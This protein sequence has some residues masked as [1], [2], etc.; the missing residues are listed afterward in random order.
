MGTGMPEA[1]PAHDLWTP[2]Q[3]SG[4]AS[5]NVSARLPWLPPA[6]TIWHV[7]AGTHFDA[8][9]AGRTLGTTALALLGDTS[10]AVICDPWTHI[11][12]FLTAP[13]ATTDWDVRETTA[14]GPTTYVVVPPLNS[15]DMNLHWAVRPSP[16]RPFTPPDQLHQ[17]LQ[18]AVE[19]QFGP[20]AE[21]PQ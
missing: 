2:K 4:N 7:E 21:N 11:H 9:R 13:S 15:R 18:A 12:Y 14:C 3:A 16:D 20:R 8:I 5:A 6:G 10:G 19:A 17:A 1:I